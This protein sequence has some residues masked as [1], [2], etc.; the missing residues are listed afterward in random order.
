MTDRFVL[1]IMKPIKNTDCVHDDPI[2]VFPDTLDHLLERKR[3]TMRHEENNRN[4]QTSET[5]DFLHDKMNTGQLFECIMTDLDLDPS[6]SPRSG[7]KYRA[8]FIRRCLIKGMLAA[9]AVGLFVFSG[10]GI[11]Q[12]PSISS[13]K[14][15]PSSDASSAKVTFHVDALFPV[16]QVNAS[17]NEKDI[18]VDVLGNQDYS[19]EVEENGYL[20]L[21][22][23]SISGIHAT[24]EISIDSIDDQAPVILSHSHEGDN[25]EIHVKDIGDSGIDYNGIYARTDSSDMIHPTCCEPSEGLVVFPYPS[26]DMYIVI[27]DLNQNRLVSVLHPGIGTGA[28]E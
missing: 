15:A 8:R 18:D 17:L 13:V 21:D 2:P 26:E 1:F 3:K 27:P 12:K 7:M 20:L 23:V 9:A 14:A 4:N 22:V 19:L 25:I 6:C 28:E 16:S 5:S 11:V 24:Q 10:T